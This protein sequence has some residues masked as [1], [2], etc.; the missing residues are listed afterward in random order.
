MEFIKSKV[1]EVLSSYYFLNKV[2][3]VRVANKC[4]TISNEGHVLANYWMPHDE[5]VIEITDHRCYNEEELEDY[6]GLLADLK[7]CVRK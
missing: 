6:L 3:E 4:I 1:F 7:E 5:L 2:D